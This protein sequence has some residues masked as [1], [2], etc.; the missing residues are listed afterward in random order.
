MGS[1]ISLNIR[2]DDSPSHVAGTDELA[3]VSTS[4]PNFSNCRNGWFGPMGRICFGPNHASDE[5]IRKKFLSPDHSQQK[6]VTWE[7]PR[8]LCQ[9]FQCESYTKFFQSNV[10]VTQKACRLDSDVSEPGLDIF[11][12]KYKLPALNFLRNKPVS[13]ITRLTSAITAHCF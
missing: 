3:Y 13:C 5:L 11:P 4:R 1:S 8:W 7:G 12:T 10:K 6:Q 9:F 2:T